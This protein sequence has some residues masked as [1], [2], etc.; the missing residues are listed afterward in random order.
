MKMRKFL[1][2]YQAH[3]D[4]Y[5]LHIYATSL[6]KAKRIAVARNI[7]EVIEGE[8]TEWEF[9]SQR[10]SNPMEALHEACFL[11]YL[12]MKAGAMDV[13]DVLGDKGVLHEMAHLLH[14]SNKKIDAQEFCGQLAHLRSIIPGY[15][16]L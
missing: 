9:V 10:T 13:D 12:A 8:L 4:M 1:T 11:S 6:A 5:A 2:K 3:G 16:P 7:G 15:E 14:L